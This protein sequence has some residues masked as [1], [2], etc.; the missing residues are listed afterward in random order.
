[1]Q[2]HKSPDSPWLLGEGEGG[3][4]SSREL[5]NGCLYSGY[6]EGFNE[7]G[8]EVQEAKGPWAK[9]RLPLGQI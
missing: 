6:T 7:V 2:Q 8:S 9:S 4:T 3:K 5:T 1:M